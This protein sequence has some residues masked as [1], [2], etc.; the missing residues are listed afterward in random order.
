MSLARTLLSGGSIGSSIDPAKY[1]HDTG[2]M[3]IAMESVEELHEIFIESFYNVEQAELAAATE[4]VELIG[5]DYEVVAEAS[6]KETFTKVKEFIQNLWTKVKAWFHNVKMYISSL[7]MNGTKFVK[8]YEKEIKGAKL[9][10]FK[11]K[12]YEYTN[13][14]QFTSEQDSINAYILATNLAFAA[15]EVSQTESIESLRDKYSPEEIY[16]SSSDNKATTSEEFAAWAFGN[17]RN[18]AKDEND[19]K[20]VSVTSLEYY[21]NIILECPSKIKL[22][23]ISKYSDRAYQMAINTCDTSAKKVG[24][25]PSVVARL[26]VVSQGLSRVQS[27]TNALVNAWKTALTERDRVYKQLIKAGLSN[28][29]KNKSNGN[30]SNGGGTTNGTGTGVIK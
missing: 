4:G 25:D 27:V 19:K 17:F 9:K 21:A 16:K 12:M 29:K 14:N 3:R 23:I 8:K 10:D 20:E 30:N 11:Y 2:A 1:S 15:Q 7:F 5:S 18:G 22:E 13:I 6:I 26:N 24:K 28:S